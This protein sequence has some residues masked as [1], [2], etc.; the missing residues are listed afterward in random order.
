MVHLWSDIDPLPRKPHNG[1][2][3]FLRRDPIMRLLGRVTLFA[4]AA[5]GL[6]TVGLFLIVGAAAARHQQPTLPAQMVLMLDLDDG[7]TE[8]TPESPF[9]KLQSNGY[10]VEEVV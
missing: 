5:V 7:L 2:M 8:A 1:E 3:R 6:L 4:L 10:S 9:A